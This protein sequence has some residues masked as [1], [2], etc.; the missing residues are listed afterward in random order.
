MEVGCIVVGRKT[1][2]FKKLTSSGQ[3]LKILKTNLQF[4]EQPKTLSS[5][6]N[7]IRI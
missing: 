4:F 1:K 5:F 3:L 2:C 7:Q 6:F